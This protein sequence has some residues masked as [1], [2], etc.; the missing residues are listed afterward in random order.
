MAGASAAAEPLWDN[1]LRAYAHGQTSGAAISLHAEPRL[2]AD[3]ASGLEVHPAIPP[4]VASARGTA[5][6]RKRAMTGAS[7]FRTAARQDP[8]RLLPLS[9]LRCVLRTRLPVSQ[10]VIRIAEALNKKPTLADVKKTETKNAD[11]EKRPAHNP[12]LPY[13]P[14][15]YVQHLVRGIAPGGPCGRDFPRVMPT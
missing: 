10:F 7:A 9:R 6:R 2:V 8:T 5:G 15:L 1:V 14:D 12:F 13:N 4:F 3:S 11:G